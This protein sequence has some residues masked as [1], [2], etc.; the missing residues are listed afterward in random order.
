MVRNLAVVAMLVATLSNGYA[1][2]VAIGT[3]S[4]RGDMRV[5]QYKVNG[6]AT[7]FDGSVVETDQATADLR[8]DK[9]VAVTM[10]TGS[11]ATFYRDHLVLQNGMSELTSASPFQVEA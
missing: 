3:V 5:D 10:S 2:S 1:G 8:L 6:N 7:L 9:G 4:A 11:R